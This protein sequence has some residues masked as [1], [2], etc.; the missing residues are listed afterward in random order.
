MIFEEIPSLINSDKRVLLPY[1]QHMCII[2]QLFYIL[3]IK[4]TGKNTRCTNSDESL[5]PV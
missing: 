1:Q 5:K 4:F 3:K 2:F